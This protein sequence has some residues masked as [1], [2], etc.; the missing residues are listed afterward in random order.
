MKRIFLF[1]CFAVVLAF[2]LPLLLYVPGRG[3]AAV[4]ETPAPAPETAA[5]IP[6]PAATPA[7]AADAEVLLSVATDAGI[8]T[9]PMSDYLTLALAGEMPAS[10][11]PE[12]LK[13]QAVALRTYALYYRARRKS[14]HPEADVCGRAECCA[15]LAQPDALREVWGGRYAEYKQKLADAVRATDGQYL[16]W[17]GAP[18]LAVFHASSA[19][20]TE[21][22]AALGVDLAYLRSVDTPETAERVRNLCST[23]EVSAQEFAA[24]IRTI[25]PEAELSGAPET[26]LGPVRLDAAGRVAAA[27]IGGASLSG[28]T[29]R[30]LFSLRS[31]GFTISR[32]DDGFLFRVRGAG[33]G[34]G[35]SQYGAQL[36]ADDGADYAAILAHYY[37]G[38]E[39]AA[40]QASAA[41]ASEV[42]H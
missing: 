22:G 26:W 10:F 35:M 24:S 4:S 1:S 2:L 16:A 23:V 8:E 6:T 36:M 30:Q 21:S 13:A 28:L 19:Q 25:A 11:A 32:T 9:M 37:P 31:T 20:N 12:A 18:A 7:C 34:L 39:L 40:L 29:L 15:A 3:Q 27:E 14:A 41:S 42:G 38:T 5:P 17:E 33:H